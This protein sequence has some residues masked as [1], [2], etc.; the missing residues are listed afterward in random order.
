MFAIIN[1]LCHIQALFLFPETFKYVYEI[2][3][4]VKSDMLTSAF[5]HFLKVHHRLCSISK[6]LRF[7][8][9]WYVKF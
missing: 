5:L 4:I 6:R 7:T 1:F 2:K 9:G 8:W 3:N